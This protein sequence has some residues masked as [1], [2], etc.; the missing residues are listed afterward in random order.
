[1]VAEAATFVAVTPA[2][3]AWATAVTSTSTYRGFQ[4]SE[5]LPQ[6]RAARL[7]GPDES[8][9]FQFDVLG[10]GSDAVEALAA[11]LATELEALAR[12]VVD[13]VVLH[14]ATVQDVRW[15]PDS[16]T[17]RPRMIV[18]AVLT[19]TAATAV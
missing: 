10:A 11:L 6:I 19:A 5:A 7:G 12:Y 3:K 18:T 4:D 16:T 17:D 9:L 2:V 13:G 14:G 8:A 15:A 1:M